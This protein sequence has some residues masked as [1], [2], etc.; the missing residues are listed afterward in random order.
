MADMAAIFSI[1]SSKFS[2]SSWTKTLSQCL[3]SPTTLLMPSSKTAYMTV[4][5]QQ[6]ALV[7]GRKRQAVTKFS[8]TDPLVGWAKK[9]VNLAVD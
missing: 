4:L 2:S 5:R 9:T 3:F 1:K 8:D 6:F 7:T